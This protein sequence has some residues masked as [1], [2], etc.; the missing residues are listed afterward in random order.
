MI[1]HKPDKTFARLASC[2]KRANAFAIEDKI[3]IDN[4]HP[5]AA[6][7][8]NCKMFIDAEEDEEDMFYTIVCLDWFAE[9]LDNYA[10]NN[11]LNG[12]MNI[13][14]MLYEWRERMFFNPVLLRG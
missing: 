10:K 5:L 9:K 13:A 4:N 14:R 3:K 8:E 12:D 1:F 2:W 11:M 7:W 6:A